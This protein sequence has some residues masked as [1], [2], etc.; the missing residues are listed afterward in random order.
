MIVLIAKVSV[1]PDGLEQF[2]GEANI[3][4]EATRQEAGVISYELV[5]SVEDPTTFLMIEQYADEAALAAHFE[6]EH[7]GRMQAV[8]GTVLAGP[9]EVTRYNVTST[10]VL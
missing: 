2:L 3:L 9:G 8:L 1:Q 10:E 5:R 7:F 4:V 6:T